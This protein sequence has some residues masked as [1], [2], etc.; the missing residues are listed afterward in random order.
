MGQS[1]EV[2]DIIALVEAGGGVFVRRTTTGRRRFVFQ[3]RGSALTRIDI[4]MGH[5]HLD[6]RFLKNLRSEAE[7]KLR[8]FHAE[9]PEIVASL[10]PHA[11]R[12]ESP[13]PSFHEQM[14]G[15]DSPTTLPATPPISS[16]EPVL[17]LPIESVEEEVP[18]EQQVVTVTTEDT[19][20]ARKKHAERTPGAYQCRWCDR[21][22]GHGAHRGRHESTIHADRY[23]QVLT[24]TRRPG[25]PRKVKASVDPVAVNGVNLAARVRAVE[26]EN[27]AM[28]RRQGVID[29][30]LKAF[31]L[32]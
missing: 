1:A 24:V 29:Q 21:V 14:Q 16:P 32:A 12:G 19:M 2:D 23:Q 3:G 26:E 9:N 22:F 5:A 13:P 4:P 20:G 18:Q 8:A 25:R 28:R 31:A 15:P 6:G 10:A 27:A 17:E 11:P 7:R 30:A